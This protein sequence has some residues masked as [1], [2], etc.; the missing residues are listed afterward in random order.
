MAPS[1]PPELYKG[2]YTASKPAVP[3]AWVTLGEHNAPRTQ[4]CPWWFVGTP[5]TWAYRMICSMLLPLPLDD[6]RNSF[7]ALPLCRLTCCRSAA[8]FLFFRPLFKP[9]LDFIDEP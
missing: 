8:V 2:S 5:G 3:P 6:L 1:R 9:R 4:S 7:S